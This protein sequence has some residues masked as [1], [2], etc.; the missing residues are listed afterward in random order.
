MGIGVGTMHYQEMVGRF[1]RDHTY[2]RAVTRNIPRRT[3]RNTDLRLIGLARYYP[4]QVTDE[5]LYWAA[6]IEPH[7]RPGSPPMPKHPL[8]PDLVYL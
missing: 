3:T 1:D 2:W 5:E 8:I 7:L 6:Y 4:G